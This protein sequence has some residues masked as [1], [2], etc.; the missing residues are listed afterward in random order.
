MW[1]DQEITTHTYFSSPAPYKPGDHEYETGLP[2]YVTQPERAMSFKK[3]FIL[4]DANRTLFWESPGP[5]S[6][7][8]T[9]RRHRKA[10]EL[11]CPPGCKALVGKSNSTGQLSRHMKQVAN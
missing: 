5:G 11:L 8:G 9:T 10:R 6:V 1:N 4:G 7:K 2:E 3:E